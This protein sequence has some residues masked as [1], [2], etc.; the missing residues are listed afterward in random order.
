M[1]ELEFRRANYGVSLYSEFPNLIYLQLRESVADTFLASDGHNLCRVVGEFSI[2][3]FT[4]FPGQQINFSVLSFYAD[5]QAA[6]DAVARARCVLRS[7]QVVSDITSH[8]EHFPFHEDVLSLRDGMAFA[9]PQFEA[10]SS[11]AC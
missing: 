9:L 8:I 2:D 6:S 4:G 7:T 11:Y 5:W 3:R 1:E 10:K